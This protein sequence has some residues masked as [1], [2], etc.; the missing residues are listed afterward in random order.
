ME[1]IGN[2][3]LY[4]QLSVLAMDAYGKVVYCL[5]LQV[6]TKVGLLHHQG[7]LQVIRARVQLQRVKTCSQVGQRVFERIFFG[8]RCFRSFQLCFRGVETHHLLI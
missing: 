8:H 1:T 4:R 7:S 5:R 2:F 6:S 3:R